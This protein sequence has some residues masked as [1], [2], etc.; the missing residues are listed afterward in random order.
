M[1]GGM[2]TPSRPPAVHPAPGTLL[3]ASPSLVDENFADSVVLLL[4]VD[5]DGAL[6][7][8][9]NRPSPLLVATV[10]GEWA[11]YTAE[12]EVLF[13]GGPV[14]QDGALALAMLRNVDDAPP[15]GFRPVLGPVGLLDL[16]IPVEEV[17]DKLVALRLFAG[18]AGWAPGQLEQEIAGGDWDLVNAD[19]LDVFRPDTTDLW[20]DVLRR[21]PGELAW[22]STR[23]A[24][25]ALN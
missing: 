1:M 3:V 13:R 19:P 5:E 21:Q 25:P 14:G 8:V 12:P 6:G 22:R 10:L 20:R 7:V 24:D 15:D 23:P 11:D 16:E 2:D 4:D 17:A 18:Y 9:I